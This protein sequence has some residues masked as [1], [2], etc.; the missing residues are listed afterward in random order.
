MAD[1]DPQPDEPTLGD[2]DTAETDRLRAAFI[3]GFATGRTGHYHGYLR[4][5]SK[6]AAATEFERYYR[7][8]L[9]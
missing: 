3:A 6:R 8:E 4:D 5:I 2:A 7:N 9:E 1:P